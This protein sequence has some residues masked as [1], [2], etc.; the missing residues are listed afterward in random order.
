LG[1][2]LHNNP[3]IQKP[4]F[5]QLRVPIPRGYIYFLDKIQKVGYS[6]TI[7]QEELNMLTGME[8]TNMSG[9]SQP[10]QIQNAVDGLS[11]ADKQEAIESLQQIRQLVEQMMAQGA[12]EEE[13][14][15]LLA[16]IGI[17]LQELDYAEQML[18][19]SE[20]QTGIKL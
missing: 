7:M 9:L 10:V 19:L 2:P 15:A 6:H 11:P 8:G 13:I 3:L 5:L 14:E 1:T 20:N 18:G 17:S 12:T 4:N 16:E